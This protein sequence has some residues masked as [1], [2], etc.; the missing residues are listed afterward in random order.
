MTLYVSSYGSN[1]IRKYSTADGSFL[2]LAAGNP[3]IGPVG[4]LVL[5]DTNTML[6]TGW[7]S[8]TIY[9]FDATSGASLGV[10][11]SGPPLN[12]P[13][14][15]AILNIPEPASATLSLASLALILGYTRRR[16]E[17]V[18]SKGTRGTIHGRQKRRLQ[19]A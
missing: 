2:G 9:K 1:E 12:R 4:H 19:N 15:L 10:F 18:T 3:L 13:N 11:N 8:N 5:P 6:V 16:Q 7:Q 14:N 17:G